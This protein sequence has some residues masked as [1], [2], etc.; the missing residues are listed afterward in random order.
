M[1]ALFGEHMWDNLM[2]GVNKWSFSAGAVEDREKTCVF[3]PKRCR[4]EKAFST[5]MMAAIEAKFHVGRNLTFAFIDSWAKHPMN[6]NDERQQ[7]AFRRES[8][9]LWHFALKSKEFAF[10]S[11]QDVL[12]ENEKLRE[13]NE[14]LNDVLNK[15]ISEI[16]NVL[17]TQDLEISRLDSEQSETAEVVASKFLK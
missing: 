17:H 11:I 16:M 9:I 7:D 4:D 2:I 6:L 12:E 3:T 1:R 13:E 14:S 10:K 15:N 8:N 5:S